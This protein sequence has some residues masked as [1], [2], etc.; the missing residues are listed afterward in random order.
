MIKKTLINKDLIDKSQTYVQI[1]S[2]RF[3][4]P[5]YISLDLFEELMENSNNIKLFEFGNQDTSI[6]KKPDI[7][8]LKNLD[9]SVDENYLYIWMNNKWKRI[10]LLDY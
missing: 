8:S 1:D 9:M 2:P 5:G 4:Q 7:K 6:N 10:A 3:K